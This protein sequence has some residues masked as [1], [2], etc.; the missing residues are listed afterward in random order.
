MTSARR[1]LLTASEAR[2]LVRDIDI[3]RSLLHRSE[4]RL[5]AAR[6][7]LRVAHRLLG[8]LPGGPE[9]EEE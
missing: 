3:L 5:D 2:K 1:A 4:T 9:S 8:G 7:N 6:V